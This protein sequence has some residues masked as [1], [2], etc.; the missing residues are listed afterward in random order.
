MYDQPLS[1]DPGLP[2]RSGLD[3]L[4]VALE[5]DETAALERAAAYATL[6]LQLF[7]AGAPRSLVADTHRA[8]IDEVTRCHRINAWV[9]EHKRVHQAAPP[10]PFNRALGGDELAP[11]DIADRAAALM[12]GHDESAG[13]LQARMRNTPAHARRLLHHCIRDHRRHGALAARI[14]VWG[15]LAVATAGTA[16]AGR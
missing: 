2:A 4:A 6:S 15:S 8:S 10:S 7:R 13:R 12:V 11:S 5:R 3:D 1:H 9:A 14:F 16:F